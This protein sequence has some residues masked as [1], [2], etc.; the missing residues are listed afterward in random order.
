MEAEF[1]QNL[2]P[3]LSF[4]L[5]LGAYYLKK[6]KWTHI[7]LILLL[8]LLHQRKGCWLWG[9]INTVNK[10]KLNSQDVQK[11]VGGGGLL[12]VLDS[13]G[14]T[15]IVPEETNR[16]GKS[17]PRATCIKAGNK[18]KNLAAMVVTKPFLY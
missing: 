17:D 11:P 14:W 5:P 7:E 12:A 4:A 2:L 1:P 6:M 10:E 18:K 13:K 16:P 9:W 8:P 3:I 15:H